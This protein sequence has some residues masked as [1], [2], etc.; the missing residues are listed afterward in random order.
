MNTRIA[1]LMLAGFLLGG[2]SLIPAYEK[3][4]LP[5]ASVFPGAATSEKQNVADLQWRTYF[6]DPALQQLIQAALQN[7]RDL[8]VA[9]LN[10]AAYQAKYR[11]R[12]ADLLPIV[13]ADATGSRQRVPADL[14]PSNQASVEGQYSVGLNMS[15]E[16]DVFGRVRSLSE[17]ALQEYLATEQAQSSARI[18]LVASVANA[19]LTWQADQQLLRITADTVDTYQRS[20]VLTQRSAEV[21][22]AT[23]LAVRQ[24]ETLLREAQGKYQQ[25]LRQVA[26]DQNLL[27]MLVGESLPLNLPVAQWSRPPTS[28]IPVGLPSDL[29]THRPDILEA[30]HRLKSAN[31]NI[32]AARAAFFPRIS[33]TA[34]GG[35]SSSELSNLF[36]A[37]SGSWSFAPIISL[38]IFNAGSLQASL[39]VSRI[40]K[41]INVARYEGVIQVAFKEVSD[42]LAATQ[43]YRQ[44]VESQQQLVDASA[45]YYRLAESRYQTGIDSS[46]TLL[47]AQRTLFSAQQTLVSDQ[48]AAR[49]AAVDLYKALG[50]G[51]DKPPI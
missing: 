38:P 21:G 22:T 41:D 28:D 45:E 33:L 37:G 11:I 1:S 35:T 47:D 5:V 9:T 18:S 15:Y 49:V 32:G 6:G 48:L 29:L 12:K 10:V 13:T 43:T 25:Y 44:Q 42:G 31:A 26:Q 36:S 14:S 4:E 2:C 7:N 8:R 50:G 30:E 3:P 17:Q 20:Y 34:G 19:W 39:D 40:G 23:A 51:W 46:L 16:L 27:V 24:T